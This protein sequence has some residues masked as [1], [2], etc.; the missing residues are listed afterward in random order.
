MNTKRCRRYCILTGV[1]SNSCLYCSQ[2]WWR[3]R[4]FYCYQAIAY[5][6]FYGY[7]VL[8]LSNSCSNRY[9]S[10]S[11]SYHPVILLFSPPSACWRWGARKTHPD[12]SVSLASPIL[13]WSMLFSFMV[14]LA[15]SVL[16]HI[17]VATPVLPGRTC[18]KIS[19]WEMLFSLFYSQCHFTVKHM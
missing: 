12:L 4:M 13:V 9:R 2:T 7:V 15:L 3:Q 6:L 16:S 8:M 14:A 1:K 18:N 11:C 19:S 10:N 17:H 5:K